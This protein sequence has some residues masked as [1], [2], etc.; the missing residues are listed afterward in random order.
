[1]LA[2]QKQCNILVLYERFK[3]RVDHLPYQFIDSELSET[4]SVF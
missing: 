2:R 4:N 3:N 1:M